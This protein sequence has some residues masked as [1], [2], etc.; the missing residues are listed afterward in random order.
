MALLQY[1]YPKTWLNYKLNTQVDEI[2]PSPSSHTY[3]MQHVKDKDNKIADFV[4]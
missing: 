3:I 1:S 4:I 2:L